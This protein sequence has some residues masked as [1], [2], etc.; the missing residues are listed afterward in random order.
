MLSSTRLS[1]I[2]NEM[3]LHRFLTTSSLCLPD[4][5]ILCVLEGNLKIRSES[6]VDGTEKR[7]WKILSSDFFFLPV[8]VTVELCP[9]DTVVCLLLRLNPAFLLDISFPEQLLRNPEAGSTLFPASEA[10]PDFL[11]MYSLY[12]TDR[13]AYE[14]RI[15]SRLY[16]C[17]QIFTATPDTLQRESGTTGARRYHAILSYIRQRIREPLTLAGT[18]DGIGLTPQYL[19]SWFQKNL[20]CTFSAYINQTK[21]QHCLPWIYYTKL[22]FA[23]ISALFHFTNTKVFTQQVVHLT[24]QTP[25]E[26]RQ[27]FLDGFGTQI[28]DSDTVLAQPLHYLRHYPAAGRQSPHTFDLS[29]A[30]TIRVPELLSGDRLTDSWRYLLNL[31][32][33]YQYSDPAIRQQLR[34]IQEQVHFRYGRICRLLDL[35]TQH[36]IHG[37]DHYG[38]EL[39]F[40]ILDLM[41]DL[42]LIPF[43]ELGFKNAKVHFQFTE[44][45]LL[46]NNENTAAYYDTLIEILPDFIHACCNRYGLKAVSSWKFSLYYD[47]IQEK[48]NDY[49]ITFWQ[50]AGYFRRIS[51]VI[52][53]YLPSCRVGGPDFNI[54]LTLEALDDKLA[55]L[56]SLGLDLDFITINA[57]GIQT[58]DGQLHAALDPDY[59][60]DKTTL[61]I[62]KIHAYYPDTPVLITEFNFCYTSR[63]YLN[64]SIFQSCFLVR[65]LCRHLDTVRGLGYF[66]LSDLSVRYSDSEKIF[67]GGNGLYT[68]N[69]LPKPTFYIYRFFCMLGSRMVSRAENYMIT[70]DTRYR[71]QG[72]FFNYVHIN[73]NAAYSDRNSALL[74]T[75]EQLFMP[76]A[77]VSIHLQVA[78]AV[79]GTYMLK[80]Y[81]LGI[82][83]GNIL[84]EWA[85]CPDL[86]DLKEDDLQFFCRISRPAVTLSTCNV[87]ESGILDF[88]ITLEPLETR[89]IVMEYI[90]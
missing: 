42:N 62:R 7:T 63:N 22:S 65:Y 33:A 80:S 28:P 55:A 78:G 59:M 49:N 27:A 54:S 44:T 1:D 51:D 16:D 90:P 35:T 67:F 2:M 40:Q 20:H 4:Y 8:G 37:R 13:S 89:L 76:A 29:S 23:D 74:K 10:L 57:Y 14:F 47:F 3:N 82:F 34:E 64:D 36:R 12:L 83:Q 60:S 45:R 58:D 53:R 72:L 56:K 6:A 88:S 41:T 77:P 32:Y 52:R 84:R 9:D 30:V 69:G 79:K 50:Y 19:S 66:T 11:E 25:E 87:T 81:T 68:C 43:L 70:A 21:A 24:G 85:K 31:G 48:E 17:L 15:I 71:I 61:T 86:T 39:I 75:P 5:G 46:I 18:A 26:C 73:E 38:F